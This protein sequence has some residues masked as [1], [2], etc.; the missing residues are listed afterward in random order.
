MKVG[1]VVKC[2]VCGYTKQPWG[3]DAPIGSHYCTRDECEGY[4]QDPQAGSLWPGETEAEFGYPVGP[5]GWRE[6][7]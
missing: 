5:Y 2:A 4:M 6:R 7:A 1:I 3:R